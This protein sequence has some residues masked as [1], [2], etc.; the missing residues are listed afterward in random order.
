MLACFSVGPSTRFRRSGFG[1]DA[2][3]NHFYS[4]FYCTLSR[5]H[6]YRYLPFW[7]GRAL[8]HGHYGTGLP[9]VHLDKVQP[10]GR[11]SGSGPPVA[12]P[13]NVLSHIHRSGS[14]LADA[15]RRKEGKGTCSPG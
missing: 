8:A 9:V 13:D 11:N 10:H 4:C 1:F 15:D 14:G 2:A 5:G 7:Y 6:V 3:Y 12:H